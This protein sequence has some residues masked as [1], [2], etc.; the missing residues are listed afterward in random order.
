MRRR[1]MTTTISY[2]EKEEQEEEEEEEDNDYSRVVG[3]TFHRTSKG[4]CR[5]RNSSFPQLQF[6]TN[7][8]Q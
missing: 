2:N 1:T 3:G 8:M 4:Y 6:Q 7:K 5:E